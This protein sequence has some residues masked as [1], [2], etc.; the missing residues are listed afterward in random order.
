MKEELEKKILD[1]IG[2]RKICSLATVREDG[3]PQNTIVDYVH[4]GLIVYAGCFKDSQKIANIRRNPKVSVTIGEESGGL[5]F[6]KGISLGGD[7][8]IV[9][10]TKEIEH[11]SRLFDKKFPYLSSFPLEQIAWI[12]II[13]IVI[14]FVDY[15]LG[16]G[17]Q[18]VLEVR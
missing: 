17:H 10:D 12:Q 9:T 3:Y 8:K 18:D 15:S 16:I 2:K 1:Y 4:D 5:S 7:A 6:T 11:I 13:P 14:H